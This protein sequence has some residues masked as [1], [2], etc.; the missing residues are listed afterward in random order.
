M[1]DENGVILKWFGACIDIHDQKQAREALLR[2]RDELEVRVQERTAEL[3]QANQSLQA[4]V[5]ERERAERES[6]SAKETAEAASRA[7]GDFLATMSHEIRTPM[8]GIL[9]MTRLSLETDLNDEQREYLTLVESS[10]ESLL[11]IINDILD[12]SKIEAGK[13]ALES[14]P[15]GLREVVAQTVRTFSLRT[16]E[17]GIQIDAVVAENVPDELVGDPGRLRQVLINLVGNAVKFT[18]QGGISVQ[19]DREPI[20]END[21]IGLRFS[22]RDTGI[23]IP[24]D[25][26][27]A[28]FAPF[29]QADGSTTRKYGGTGLGLAISAKLVSLMGGR[30]WVDSEP[31]KGSAFHFISRFGRAELK[32]G[33]P[34]TRMGST[35]AEVVGLDGRSLRVLLAEDNMVNQR[36]AVRLIERKGHSIQVAGNGKEAIAAWE[37]GCFD[38]ILMDVHMPEMGG[39]E[40]TA[41]IREKERERANG[42]RVPIIAMT[43]S[44]MI[45]DRERCL[46]VG[47]D[48]YVSKPVR[49]QQLWE[50]IAAV[51]AKSEAESSA[52]EAPVETLPDLAGMISAFDGDKE[53]VGELAAIFLAEL[54]NMLCA[55]DTALASE[56]APKLRLAAHTLKGA[57]CHFGANEARDVA[58]LLEA[59]GAQADFNGA[60]T[61]FDTLRKHTDH[62]LPILA[63][64]AHLGAVA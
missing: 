30:V 35:L 22:V 33:I 42:R 7:K 59:K 29:E 6:R 23:G 51:R 14:I 39:F 1:R 64:A 43:A 37:N 24:L 13:L 18:E 2:A 11:I 5:V 16:R 36:L 28:I 45:G 55:I 26:L 15:F 57:V 46:E 38:V 4:E 34:D 63:E 60:R 53:L 52:K 27:S 49:E 41:A 32:A 61:L 56:D 20:A 62:L 48:S 47:M 19:V 50:A 58:E 44:A 25:K 3:G 8:N 12:F 31:A 10:A 17:K 54:P 21:E 40:A 9:G